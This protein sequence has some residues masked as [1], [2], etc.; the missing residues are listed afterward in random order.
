MQVTGQWLCKL[1]VKSLQFRSV[2][3]N[4]PFKESSIEGGHPHGPVFSNGTAKA[5]ISEEDAAKL[6]S[7]GVID[8]R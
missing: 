5:V 4:A 1:V 7:A 8:R 3:F 2:S 6:I